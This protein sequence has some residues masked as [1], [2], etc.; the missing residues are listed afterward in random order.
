VREGPV[1][2][3]RRSSVGPLTEVVAA[4]AFLTR[5]PVAGRAGVNGHSGAAGFGLVGAGLGAVA[6]VPLLVVGGAHPALAAL[7]AVGVLA[8]LDGGLHLDGL[9]DTFDALAA[10]AGAAER[11]RTDPRVGPAG[12]VAIVVVVAIAAASLAELVERRSILA[13]ATMIAAASVSRAAAPVWAVV[14]RRALP[15]AQGLGSW[16]SHAASRSAAVVSIATAVVVTVITMELAGIVVLF[17]VVAGLMGGSL[18]VAA[19]V[20]SRRQL[21]GDGYGAAVELTFAAILAATALLL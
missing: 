1:A 10:P 5:L 3:T 4:A 20:A 8:A 21:D 2:L 6:A 17:G 19:I 18:A 7:A 11:A 12:L 13:A 15:R 14:A 9:G 16:F